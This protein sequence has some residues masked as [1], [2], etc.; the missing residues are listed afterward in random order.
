MNYNTNNSA[1]V[2]VCHLHAMHCRFTS[3]NF[4]WRN[5]A[6]VNLTTI[7][8][9]PVHIEKLTLGGYVLLRCA[10][11]S[12]GRDICVKCKSLASICFKNMRTMYFSSAM[13]LTAY[14]HLICP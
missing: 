13:L 2:Y 5:P 10:V 6:K 8:S 12:S 14:P 4:S 3:Y 7:L 11:A 9:L 1:N